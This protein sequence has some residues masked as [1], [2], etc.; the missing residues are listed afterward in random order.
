MSF[1]GIKRAALEGTGGALK[2]GASAISALPGVSPNVQAHLEAMAARLLPTGGSTAQ[3]PIKQADGSVAWGAQSGGGSAQ[4]FPDNTALVKNNTDATKL[5]RVDASGVGAGTTR[6]LTMPNSDVNL[7]ADQAAGTASPRTLGPGAQQA[8][9]GNDSR[10][11]DMLRLSVTEVS[12]TTTAALTT[13]AFGTMH[14][15]SG[16]TADYTVNLPTAVGNAG[17]IIAFRGDSA[18]TKVVTL[19]ANSTETIGGNLTKAIVARQKTIIVSDGSNWYILHDYRLPPAVVDGGAWS[20]TYTISAGQT[21]TFIT[22]SPA[23]S[24]TVPA[25]GPAPEGYSW[26]IML[27]GGTRWTGVGTGTPLLLL[28]FDGSGVHGGSLW[29]GNQTFLAWNALMTPATLTGS[30]TYTLRLFTTVVTTY[31]LASGTLIAQ[32][33]LV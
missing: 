6:V 30:N 3:V 4:P 19:D 13:S 14:K 29:P 12:V 26:R 24:V 22:T 11:D 27:L 32:P 31:T 28:S 17:K 15:L 8:A 1:D 25:L 18:L 5:I 23:I 2:I 10:F 21:S 16:T 33:V 9:P 20:Q 7:A